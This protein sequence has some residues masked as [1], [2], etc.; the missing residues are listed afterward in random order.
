MLTCLCH[1][2][3]Y[4]FFLIASTS[5]AAINLSL[6]CL[7]NVINAL[8]SGKTHVPY[9]ESKLTRILQDSLGGNS[10]TSKKRSHNV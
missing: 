2:A 3:C 6:S 4:I 9:R 1:F 7:G 8:V 5:G 10:I